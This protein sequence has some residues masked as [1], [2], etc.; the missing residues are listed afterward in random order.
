MQNRII[1]TDY[2]DD[3]MEILEQHPEADMLLLDL[4][5]PGATGYSALVNLRTYY[6]QLPVVMISAHEEPQLMRRALDLGAMGFIPKS[7]DTELLT[8]ALEAVM[9]G[10][11]RKS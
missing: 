7:A 3:L 11:D 8:E 6:P 5:M 9:M 2:I 4:T 10:N 1:V